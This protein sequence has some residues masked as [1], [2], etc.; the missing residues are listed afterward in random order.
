MKCKNC[1][2]EIKEGWKVC[3]SCGADLSKGK[4]SSSNDPLGKLGERLSK[5]E[6]YLE[7]KAADE[8]DGDKGDK[9][10]KKKKRKP[11]FS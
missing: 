11:L 5:V 9:D 10:G 7:E 8:E 2:E 4:Y 1:E 6:Q 3:P